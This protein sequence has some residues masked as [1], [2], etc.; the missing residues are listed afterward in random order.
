[1][2]WVASSLDYWSIEKWDERVIGAGMG[3][4]YAGGMEKHTRYAELDGY[5]GIAALMIV[6]YHCY[7][8]TGQRWEDNTQRYVGQPLHLLLRNLNAGVAFFFVLSCFV[9]FLPL[10][11]QRSM[12]PRH[13][14]AGHFS[15]AAPPVF[16]RSI[17]SR[18]WQYGCWDC[19]VVR[20]ASAV[21]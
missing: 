13:P 6:A 19:P 9:I 4:A 18:R 10:R 20:W 3:T 12:P 15:R 17:V 11:A 8:L 21:C 7:L 1:V 5:R 14:N 16:C 2:L